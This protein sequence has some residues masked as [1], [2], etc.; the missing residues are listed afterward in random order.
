MKKNYSLS[1]EKKW[2][3][4]WGKEKIYKFNPQKKATF[5]SVDT[6]P[7]TV[8]GKMHLGHA[9][10]YTH[11]DIIAR[12]HRMIGENVFFPF[13][14]DDN[15]LPTEKLVEKE[16]NV[17]I[18]N[19]KRNE[20][21]SLCQKTLKKLRPEF[22]RDWKNIGISCDFDLTYST[23]S[24]DVQRL[25]QKFFI[26]LYHKNRAYR[27][28]FPV[29]WC[30]NCQT[31]IAQA[32]LEDKNIES[33][34]VNIKFELEEEGEII[35]ATTRPELLSSCVA[36]F[37]HPNDKRYKNLINKKA[38]V[39]IFGQKVLILED[40]KVN[41]EK[42]TGIV[43]CCTFG[44]VTDVEW[45]F[46]H[47]LPL[48]I[49]INPNG[50]M[51]EL[52]QEYQGLKIKE[53]RQ[54]I[55]EDLEKEGKA[56]KKE[57][58]SHIV[59]VHERCGTEAEI[60]VNW[61]WFIKYLDLKDDFIKIDK[62]I[63]WF[64]EYM[65]KRYEN[66][67]KGLKWDWCISRQR[68][69]GIPFPVWYCKRCQKIKIAEISQLPV[70]PLNS[71]PKTSCSCGSKEFIPEESVLDTWATSS[72]TPQIAIDLIKNKNIKE[73]LFPMSLRPQA[74]DIINFWLFYTI[75]RSK[76]HFNKIPWKTVM[77]SGFVLDPKGEKM[78]KSKGNVVFPQEIISKYGAD[79]LRHW[80]AKAS[81][82]EDIRWD[83]KEINASKRT[84]IK[85]WNAA[86][87]CLS[88]LKD[89][90]NKK[91]NF[92]NLEDE[93]KWILSILEET[94]K[95]YHYNLKKFEFKKSREVIDNFFWKYFC[96]NY[97]EIVKPRFYNKN[98]SKNSKNAAQSVL[99]TLLLS[100]LKLY[101]PFMPHITEE[102]YQS[103]FKKWEKEKSIHLSLLPEFNKKLLNTKIKKD[104]EEIIDLISSVRKYKSE[105]GFSLKKEI[106]KLIIESKNKNKIEK[107]SNLL[108]SV[109]NIKIIE[110]KKIF[111]DSINVNSNIK[112]QIEE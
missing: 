21:I 84:I 90:N 63:K 26:D 56:I 37:V 22:I 75:A 106:N 38:I 60:L 65:R 95:D 1:L 45:Y 64:P 32:D 105:K 47:K 15:G 6:P 44:D 67:V 104:F 43:M 52:S 92:K 77:I 99:Y 79:V 51:N 4:F 14:T 40:E 20:F 62:K 28:E 110:F 34:F 91:I 70:D 101:A 11:I 94:I 72:L 33:F 87:F 80:A 27:G 108:K 85:L 107:H 12:Y 53:A 83:E 31:A 49:S 16:N 2:Q 30:S 68:Y 97:L 73:K 76:L 96:D 58:I 36:I 9:F 17:N 82:G 42:G 19:M 109:M 18:F 23:I 100:V 54:K 50:T 13:G 57:K 66:W 102:I 112:I 39:P 59:N 3:K 71:K 35:I 25:S 10:S 74:H 81:L 103:Y 93:D 86:R 78:S 111:Q 55:I 69:F 89:F 48:K 8:S 7:P 41:P 29:L 88:N 5:F 46:D 61:Q 24:K 98:I